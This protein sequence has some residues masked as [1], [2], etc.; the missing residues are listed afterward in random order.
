MEYVLQR[1][2]CIILFCFIKFYI[3]NA[4]FSAQ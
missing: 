2:L 3:N 4:L 1:T